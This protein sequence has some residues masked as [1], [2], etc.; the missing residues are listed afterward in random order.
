MELSRGQRRCAY[1]GH[2]SNSICQYTIRN[3]S[4]WEE[5]G[6]PQTW[7]LDIVPELPDIV[8]YIGA[9]EKRIV[10]RP[11]WRIR[12]VSPFLL[13]SVTPKPQELVGKHV[14]AVTRMGKRIVLEMEDELFIVIHLMIAGR[15]R[16][17]ESAVKLAGKAMLAA[18]DFENGSLVFTEAASNK[19]ASLHLVRGNSGLAEHERGGL[20]VLDSDLAAFRGALMSENHTLKRSLTDPRLFSGIGNAYSDEILHGARMS[21]VK[22][23][24]RLSEEEVERLYDA[25]RE[26]LTKWVQRLARETGDGFPEKVTA[27]WPGMAVH[28]RFGEPCPDCGSPVQRIIYA[29]NEANYCAKCQTDGKLLADRSLSRLLKSDW[30]RTLE[31]MEVHRTV[32]RDDQKSE[33]SEKVKK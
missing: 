23:T 33:D 16:W 21:P 9:L 3:R 15:L 18:F 14:T 32:R 26:V 19:R 1:S 29:E 7:N 2:V 8:T 25:V 28:G 30:P 27:F 6:G 13:R 10:G 22:L 24:S 31:E 5:D 11:L 4:P 20:E 12:I 17:K